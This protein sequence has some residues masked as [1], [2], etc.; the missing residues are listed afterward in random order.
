VEIFPQDLGSKWHRAL[1]RARVPQHGPRPGLVGLAG[2][3]RGDGHGNAPA[4]ERPVRDRDGNDAEPRRLGPLARFWSGGNAMDP[5]AA[6]DGLA[7]IHPRAG[8][9]TLAMG[10]SSAT[11]LVPGLVMAASGEPTGALVMG[12]AVAFMSSLGLLVPRLLFGRA[13][14]VVGADEIESLLPFARDDLDRAYLTLA[15]DIARQAAASV[16]QETEQVVRGALRALGEAIENLPLSA[17]P[18]SFAARSANGSDMRGEAARVRAEAGSEP[19]AITR[20]SLLR[21]ADALDRRAS[22]MERDCR[23]GAPCRRVARRTA[24]P[25]RSLTR[26][27]ERP[28][29]HGQQRRQWRSRQ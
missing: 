29:L 4:P 19:D 20:S 28:W 8:I 9:A 26:R 5:Q 27:P 10:I 24:G 15:R 1:V 2:L 12:G 18:A 7:A 23:A 11:M 16:S 22:A 13:H 14:K 21:Q 6:A 25:D 3:I 17:A